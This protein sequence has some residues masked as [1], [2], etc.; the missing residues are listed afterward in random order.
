MNEYTMKA[1]T[2]SLCPAGANL[3]EWLPE[4]KWGN[5]ITANFV[6]GKEPIRGSHWLYVDEEKDDYRVAKIVEI[7]DNGRKLSEEEISEIAD[8]HYGCRITEIDGNKMAGFVTMHEAVATVNSTENMI[9][10]KVQSEMDRVVKEGLCT[11]EEVE[12]RV[13][14]MMD[15]HVDE[16]LLLRVLRKY[17]H[18]EKNVQEPSC[19]YVDPFLKETL[20]RKEEPIIS[21]VLRQAVVRNG[22]VLNGEKS[23]GKNVLCDTIAWLLGMPQWVFTCSRQMTTATLYGRQTT[24][25]KAR[26]ALYSDTALSGAKALA[27]LRSGQPSNQAVINAAAQFELFSS[28]AAAT[29]IVM[30]DSAVIE[31]LLDGGVLVLNEWNFGEAN[32]LASFLN[33]TLDGTKYLP[34]EGRGDVLINPDCV[35]IATQN[36]DYTGCE[37]QN[38]AT[39]SRLCRF[40]IQQPKSVKNVLANAVSAEVRKH[41]FDDLEISKEMIEQADTF[42][43]QCVAGIEAGQLSN[44]ALSIRGFARAISTAAESGGYS[45]L[46]RQLELQIINNCPDSEQRPLMTM[47][48][49]CV[50]I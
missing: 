29:N 20:A 21:E 28:R 5:E 7:T 44:A 25:T 13:R 23:V 19:L 30:E 41:G 15:N 42:Y 36:P 46:R 37:E 3:A 10:A 35:L 18:Y 16:F 22:M 32:L 48:E 43:G 27:W 6:I 49:R 31:W 33:P 39:L 24:D 12:K 17:R 11:K 1:R 45:S 50:T 26:D 40:N 14:Y 4:L 38:E 34:L 2:T 9:S 8:A 47:L